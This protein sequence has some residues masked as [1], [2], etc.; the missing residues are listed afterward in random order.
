MIADAADALEYAHTVGIV[1]RDIKPGNLMIDAAGKL[2]V[3]DFG[4]A[5]FGPDAGLTL[6]GDLLGTLRYMAPEQALARHGLADHRVD[7]Y[8]LGCTLYEMLTGRP[9]VGGEDKAEIVRHIA[10]EEPV[11]LRKLDKAIPAELETIT[12][13]CLAK[14][15]AERYTTAGDLAADLRRLLDDKPIKARR[16]TVRQRL[17]RWTRRHP[18]V[19]AAG[20]LI[21]GLLL[22]GGWAWHREAKHGDA[23]ALALAVE[24]D[25]LR[26][27]DRLPEAIRA[28]RHAA[29]LLPRFGG[30]ATLRREIDERVADLRLL[31]RL[32]EARLDEVATRRMVTVSI[33]GWR[34]RDSGRP[35]WTTV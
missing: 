4:L 13:K 33:L 23:A 27:A 2:W 3:A 32:E 29:D 5:R 6:S 19:T 18:S 1:H 10:F 11:A 31:N 30:D 26:D 20:G 24:A 7:V 9:A 34:R 17:I 35:S 28:A 25:H 15:P 21:A 16:P 8:G 12:L 14:N 22:A